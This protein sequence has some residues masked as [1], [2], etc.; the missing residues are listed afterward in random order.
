MQPRIYTYKIT[1]E[2]VSYYYYGS[3]K[4]KRY[5]EYYMGSPV[6]HKWCWDFYTPKK[7]IL[8]FFDTRE[9]SNKL[10]NILIKYFINDL[11]CLN[12]NCGGIISTEMCK[13]GA[14]TLVE[15]KLGIHSR[16]REKIIEDGNIGRETQKKLGI[17]VYG[18]TPQKRSENGKKGGSR[19]VETGHI[20]N[21]GKKYGKLC[22]Q[23]NIGMF[24]MSEEEKNKRSSKGGKV[25]GNKAYE[26]KTGIHNFTKEKRLEVSS[27][28]GKSSSS[29][30][31]KCLVTG[32][33]STAPGLAS[34]QRKR[35]IDT[36]LR[37]KIED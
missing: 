19:N 34:Y 22:Y 11:N 20:Q 30:K 29:Q 17:G 25:S 14:K 10:E 28:G 23:N 4:E 2:E 32:Y 31:W 18:L 16:T 1:F 6:T 3:H 7:Q 26:N 35:N 12:E 5:N 13:K 15:N 21:L 8:E 27:K 37:I 24:G 33:I 9:D 36:T